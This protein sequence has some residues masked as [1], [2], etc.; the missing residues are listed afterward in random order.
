MRWNAA[1]DRSSST[2][3][4]PRYGAHKDDVGSSLRHVAATI[5]M[6]A[7]VSLSKRHRVVSP[8][9]AEDNNFLLIR[10]QVLKIH[11]LIARRAFRSH[12]ASRDSQVSS[13]SF[14]GT[15]IIAAD[16]R[17]SD[18]ALLKLSNDGMG[19]WAEAVGEAEDCDELVVYCYAED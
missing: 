8:V 18:V 5:H 14:D 12:M 15:C 9:A 13:N 6:H 1:F 11:L 3:I 17:D 2:K 19:V 16:Y 4:P 7:D 10:H